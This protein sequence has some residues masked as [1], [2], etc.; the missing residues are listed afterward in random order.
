MATDVTKILAATS[1]GLAYAGPTT[2]AAPTSAS[3]T[4]DGGFVELGVVSDDGLVED[5]NTSTVKINNMAGVTVRT[6]ITETEFTFSLT[7]LQTDKNVLAL[8]H[9]GSTVSWASG[10]AKIDVVKT[11]Q[12]LKSFVFD[13][14]DG[15]DIVRIYIP[16]GEVTDVGPI[17]YKADEAAGYQL[18]ITAYPN[19]VSGVALTKFFNDVSS[20]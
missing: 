5:P 8:Y 2:T 15:S 13:V 7:L 4:L 12:N 10:G 18:T 14:L 6:L 3:A 19:S 1:G 16:S 17:N 11:T 20:S 9:G